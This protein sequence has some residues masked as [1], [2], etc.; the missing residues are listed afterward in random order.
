LKC[1]GGLGKSI[2]SVLVVDDYERWRR[3]VSR[4]LQRKPE[5]LVVSEAL[6]GSQAVRKAQ[7]LHPDLILLDIGLPTV[8]G[9]EAAR[10]ILQHAPET[11]ILFVSEQRS[12]DIVEEALRAGGRGYV[13]KSNAEPNYC[14]RWK[15]FFK[16]SGL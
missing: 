12:S 2:F 7:E 6:D 13:V 11:K 14:L 10:R 5:V 15:P 4:E 9:I 1:G 16:V 3:F 8:N